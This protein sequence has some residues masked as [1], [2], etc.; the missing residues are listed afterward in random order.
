MHRRYSI[1]WLEVVEA[2][3]SAWK[4]GVSKSGSEESSISDLR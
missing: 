2:G 1:Y 3:A 4:I